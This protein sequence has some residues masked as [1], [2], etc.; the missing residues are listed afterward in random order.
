MMHPIGLNTT[1]TQYILYQCS[2]KS[3]NSFSKFLNHGPWINILYSQFF[4]CIPVRAR[5]VL[6]RRVSIWQDRWFAEVYLKSIE[7]FFK[8]L[9]GPIKIRM[10]SLRRW[11]ME[12]VTAVYWRN[13]QIPN[14]ASR[15]T[16]WY[17]LVCFKS[18]R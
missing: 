7:L 16:H 2:Q 18:T 15:R 3:P 10:E 4:R 6:E 8:I 11:H 17:S 1:F 12:T 5:W 9:Q 13:I 14:N